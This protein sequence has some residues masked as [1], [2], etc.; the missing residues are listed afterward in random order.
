MMMIDGVRALLQGLAFYAALAVL[1][2][3]LDEWGRR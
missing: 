3:L 1:L 2:V